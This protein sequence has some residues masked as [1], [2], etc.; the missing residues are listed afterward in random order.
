MTEVG[1]SHGLDDLKFCLYE[2]HLSVS[3]NNLTK[4]NQNES[5]NICGSVR[6]HGVFSSHHLMCGEHYVCYEQTEHYEYQRYE[7]TGCKAIL[8]ITSTVH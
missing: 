8:R 3:H 7:D 5:E 6:K 4:Q 1:P 2:R